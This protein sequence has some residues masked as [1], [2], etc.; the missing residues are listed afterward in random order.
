MSENDN[1]SDIDSEECPVC[2]EKLADLGSSR[3]A[4]SCG[5]TFC[6]D[7]LVKTLVTANENGPAKKHIICPICRHV[8]FLSKKGLLRL[9]GPSKRKKALKVPVSP[10]Q[11]LHPELDTPAQVSSTDRTRTNQLFH[12][13]EA[14]L[15]SR[16]ASS[17]SLP[18]SPTCT[19]QIFFISGRG[20]PMADEDQV[21]VETTRSRVVFSC[22]FQWILLFTLLFIIVAVLVVV[23]PWV[24]GNN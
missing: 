2:Y 18:T 17:N 3:R 5:H 8:T 24:L 23:L 21:S 11:A 19:S 14:R 1:T 16:S 15:F 10:V 4:L 13:L 6:H 9:H 7:C 20:R 22:Q 12:Y